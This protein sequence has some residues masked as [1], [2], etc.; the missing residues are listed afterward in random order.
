MSGESLVAITRRDAS[1]SS[2]VRGEGASASSSA[3]PQPSSNASRRRRSKRTAGLRVAPRPLTGPTGGMRRRVARHYEQSKN[4]ERI[5][6]AA[7]GW[8][9]PGLFRTL[10]YARRR[11]DGRGGGACPPPAPSSLRAI[12]VLSWRERHERSE[13]T[14]RQVL[15]RRGRG[16]GHR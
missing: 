4:I 8:L 7:C 15:L 11:A 10:L 13:R 16:D 9:W 5:P 12:V 6:A 2:S 1:G 14:C 3:V